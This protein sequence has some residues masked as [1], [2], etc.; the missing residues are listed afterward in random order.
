MDNSISGLYRILPSYP[1]RPVQPSDKD[2]ESNKEDL[3]PEREAPHNGP[4]DQDGGGDNDDKP[5]IDEYV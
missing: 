4:H 1:V 5:T 3:P 2:R